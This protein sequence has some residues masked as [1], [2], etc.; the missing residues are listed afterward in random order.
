M[1][2]FYIQYWYTVGSK[3]HIDQI[4]FNAYFWYTHEP[5]LAEANRIITRAIAAADRGYLKLAEINTFPTPEGKDG[6]LFRD[7]RESLWDWNTGPQEPP[8]GDLSLIS[9]RVERLR[10][11]DYDTDHPEPKPPRIYEVTRSEVL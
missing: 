6:L 8:I 7:D 4:L 10:T 11:N 5:T 9:V 2:Q 3:G 1:K